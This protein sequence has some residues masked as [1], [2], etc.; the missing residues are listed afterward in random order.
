[1]V[2]PAHRWAE[3]AV[4]APEPG[5]KMPVARSSLATVTEE[6]KVLIPE[7]VWLASRRL[8]LEER[9]VSGILESVL[10]EPLIV[11]LLRT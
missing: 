5:V 8:I 6:V 7:M 10:L 9:A 1:M 3:T 11:L 4:P 2:T